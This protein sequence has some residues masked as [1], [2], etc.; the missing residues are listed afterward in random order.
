MRLPRAS[1]AEPSVLSNVRLSRRSLL[2]SA[3]RFNEFPQKSS[4]GTDASLRRLPFFPQKRLPRASQAEPSVLSNVRLSRRSLLRSAS[5]FNAFPQK[6]S[7][8][9]DASLR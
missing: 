7:A 2:R 4:A 5:R 3:S 6:S 9:T 8:G 1:Q